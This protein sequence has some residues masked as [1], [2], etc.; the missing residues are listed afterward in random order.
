MRGD[1]VEHVAA[2]TRGDVDDVHGRAGRAQP[3]DRLAQQRLDVELA[4]ADAAPADR[5]EVVAVD[6]APEQR[7]AAR[8]IA[9]DVV[10]RAAGIEAGRVA[11]ANA[12][13]EQRRRSRRFARVAAQYRPRGDN[14]GSG[15]ASASAS[16]RVGPYWSASRRFGRSGGAANTRTQERPHA[17][18]GTRPVALAQRVVQEAVQ[19]VPLLHARAKP[20]EER[21]L[22]AV[23]HD[24]IVR[25]RSAAAS[26]R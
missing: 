10:E 12:V 23:V 2:V 5:V 19:H 6:Q 22:R 20:V 25:R 26:A 4:L 14:G 21:V 8:A 7:P 17:V 18:D 16:S 24:P 13:R 9:V 3:R 1:R 15:A 11:E